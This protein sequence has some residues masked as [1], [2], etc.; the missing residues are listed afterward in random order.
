MQLHIANAVYL[1]YCFV[2]VLND[3][4]LKIITNGVE[5]LHGRILSMSLHFNIY[6]LGLLLIWQTFPP[7]NI[8]L[9]L[10]EL[11]LPL[12]LLFL[13]L[14]GTGHYMGPSYACLLLA[15]LDR[16]NP[17]FCP[18]LHHQLGFP[19]KT[20]QFHHLHHPAPVWTMC[21][22]FL[23]LNKKKRKLLGQ[24]ASVGI[25]D[26]IAAQLSPLYSSLKKRTGPKSGLTISL[27]RCC[28]TYWVPPPVFQLKFPSCALF[29]FYLL[30][31][32]H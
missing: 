5:L 2:F 10:A 22:I 13:F 4:G 18:P 32:L 26:L 11:V 27:H 12:L 17:Q 31:H 20:P 15:V 19:C 24:A 28:M 14:S 25:M 30:L 29:Q 9:C 23:S 21:D 6:I 16:T 3:I 1:I 8:V 7:T